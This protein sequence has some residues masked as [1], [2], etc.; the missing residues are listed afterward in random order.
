MS[1][2]I[3]TPWFKRCYRRMLV[4]MHIPD[5]DEGFLAK[6]DPV[7]MADLYAKANL[8]SVMFYCQSHVGL[9]YW[10]T[11]T[12]KMHAGL[13]GRDVVGEMLGLLKDRGMA[14]VAYYSVIFNNWAFLEHPDWRMQP[15]GDVEGAYFQHSRYGLCC[16]NHPEYREFAFAQT[17]ELVTGYDFDG[18]FFDM[19]FWPVVCTCPHCRGRYE[20]ETGR[21]IPTTIDW[22]DPT[23]CEFQSARER[24][25]DEFGRELTARA[26]SRKPGMSVYH[27]FATSIYPWTLGVPFGS[28][29]NHD[30][31][32]ADFYGDAIEQLVASKFM[33]NLSGNR[34][35]EFMTSR[36]V[37]LQDH[38]RLKSYDQMEM[39]A[40]ASTLFSAAFLFIDAV[41]LDGTVNPEVYDRV[42][43]VYEGISAY[44]PFLGGEPVEDIGVYFSSESRMDFGDNGVQ[45]PGGISWAMTYPHMAALRGVCRV[46]QQAHLPFGIITRK[47]LPDLDRYKA[48]ILPN[49]LRMDQDEADALREYVRG[50][51]RL[52]A[53]RYTSLTDTSG[54]RLDDFALADLFGCHFGGDD[55]GGVNYIRPVDAE[56]AETIAPQDYVSQVQTGP[57]TS[58]GG[59]L[60]LALDC[61]GEVLARLTLPYASPDPGSVFDQRWGSIHS[62][63]PWEDTDQPV[64]V[65]NQFGDGVCV[66]SAAD[67]ETVD[68][69]VN[70]RLLVSLIRS[71][72]G[73]TPGYTAD[74]HPSVWVNAQHQPEKSAFLVGFLNYQAQLPPIPIESIPFTLRPIAG[75]EFT[76]LVTLPSEEPIE[77]TV[78]SDGVLHA[79]ARDLRVLKMLRAEYLN[80]E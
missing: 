16:P 44:E 2:N 35:V 41:N 50:G 22:F 51:G 26:K 38:V 36:C 46:L 57:R 25:L 54:H 1:D 24:W 33:L 17:D 69:D 64:L 55:L 60:R 74:A 19:T 77:F 78:D 21:A 62:S 75:T 18:F 65:R 67:I 29:V 32:G 40:S 43:R 34:P 61:E 72:I 39:Q 49:V 71:M 42:G 47:Q 28:A 8:T 30:Y 58:S 14:S 27:N 31:L 56:I 37:N 52:Y 3:S 23:W 4:D 13:R 59:T 20:R 9:C 66:Y 76:R 12:G 11:K 68:S 79:E 10:P 63:P 73:E 70:A 7:T 15:V 53:S 80:A 45:P 6:Y 5:W 48:I